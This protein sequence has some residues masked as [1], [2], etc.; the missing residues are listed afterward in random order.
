[1]SAFGPKR[2]CLAAPHMSAFGGKAD[3]A[4][5]A[6]MS[7]FDP[8]RISG[9]IPDLSCDAVRNWTEVQ[10]DFSAYN[11]DN[12]NERIRAGTAAR[13]PLHGP[14]WQRRSS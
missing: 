8:K 13:S 12:Q 7:A 10:L 9:S 5:A 11:R 2:T 1:M 14:L 3:I 4:L 6:Q